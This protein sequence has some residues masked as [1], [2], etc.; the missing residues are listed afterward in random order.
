M[1]KENDVIA[2]IVI[3][4][5]ILG[6]ILSICCCRCVVAVPDSEYGP[7]TNSKDG[8]YDTIRVPRRLALR[9]FGH[10]STIRVPRQATQDGIRVPRG[11]GDDGAIRVPR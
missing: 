11:N 1:A 6:I 3:V 2:I 4:Y 9:R 10:G 7:S 8:S 5:M